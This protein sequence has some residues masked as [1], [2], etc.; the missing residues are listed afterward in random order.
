VIEPGEA[1]NGL[2]A[3]R[4]MIATYLLYLKIS[5]LFHLIVGLLHMFGF[6]LAETHHLYLFSSSFTDF[7]RRINIYWKDFIQK[8]V[9]NPVYFALRKL[10]DTWAI[11]WATLVAFTATWLLHSYQWFWIRGVFPVV[12]ADL[13]F[14][15][16]LGVVV[17]VNVL[18]ES[19][20]GRQRSLEMQV[21]TFREGV[22]HALK[23]A[24]TFATICV[25]WTIWS[26][27]NL[28]ELGLVW[29]ALLNS[30]P[31][32]LAVLL[33]IPIGIGALGAILGGRK[34]EVFGAGG[35]DTAAKAF[36]PQVAIASAIAGAFI[37]M[38]LR[39]AVLVPLSPELAS[40]VRGVR[41][42]RLNPD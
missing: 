11:T 34:R 2:G 17:L 9:F 5:G 35:T 16:G 30:G 12:W 33:G 4:Y 27:P 39:P 40:L 23:A 19:R 38:A 26:T 32:D 14:W 42:G 41:D 10:G 1:L 31:V 13:V 21:R 29:R 25:L 36:W 18:L 7:W 3:A 37:V 15:L 8:L 6:G 22:L 20:K 24:G 28:E